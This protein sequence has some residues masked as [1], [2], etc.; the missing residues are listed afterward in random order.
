M[1]LLHVHDATVALAPTRRL[2]EAWTAVTAG[3]WEVGRLPAGLARHCL[4]DLD[5]R[6]TD[7]ALQVRAVLGGPA[8][9]ETRLFACPRGD[10][11]A[12]VQAA[13]L[14]ATGLIDRPVLDGDLA[15]LLAET[16]G[17]E[18]RSEP[19][20]AVAGSLALDA[21]FRAVGTGAWVPAQRFEAVAGEI[22]GDIGAEGLEAWLDPILAHHAGTYRH[23]LLVTGLTSAFGHALG[24]GAGDLAT[25]TLAAL[26]HDVGKAAIPV[27][28]LDKP[29]AL[30]EAET[31]VMQTHAALGDAYLA[32]RSDLPAEIRDVV[33]HHH[34]YLDGSGYP[35]GLRGA[36][37]GDL[38]RLVTVAD[39]FAALVEERAYKSS[40]PA[41]TAMSVLREMAGAG[42]LESPLV[43]A[44]APVAAQ[45]LGRPGP[46][47]PAPASRRRAAR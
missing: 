28:I 5:L 43:E 19:A 40:L 1:I 6:D 14:G 32:E 24:L 23:C 15:A 11:H 38:T 21:A 7:T 33:R 31:A 3:L 37:I 22:A 45:L 34:E 8:R 2:G 29:T 36:E 46:R 12:G 17:R 25:L 18:G 27:R 13:A 39:I 4:F 35:D 30:T 10:R 16:A 47:G 26:L 41:E 9:P 44:F 42:R 20:S